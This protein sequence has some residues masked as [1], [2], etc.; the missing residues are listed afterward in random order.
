M[1]NTRL[2]FGV[3]RYGQRRRE[4]VLRKKGVDITG[5]CDHSTPHA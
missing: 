3:R 1:E 5:V 2:Q 4:G